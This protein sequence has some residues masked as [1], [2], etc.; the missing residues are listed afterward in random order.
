MF[1]STPDISHTDQMS[2]VIRY[3][4]IHNGKV[5][6]REV[7]LGLF[8][9][10]GKKADDLSSDIL[11]NLKSDGLDIMMCKSSRLRQCC[12]NVWNPWRCSGHFK[13]KD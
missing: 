10:R 12:Y 5:E 7:F 1:D 6:V 3:V 11:T 4:K 9:L 8:P 2:E 13:K